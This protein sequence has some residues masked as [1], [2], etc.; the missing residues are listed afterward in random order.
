LRLNLATTIY[1]ASG[2]FQ[3]EVFNRA[4]S[5]LPQTVE[6][7][8]ASA[9]LGT[10]QLRVVAT[11]SSLGEILADVQVQP[12]AFTPQGDG[13]NDRAEISYSLFRILAGTAVSV[14][15]YTLSGRRIWRQIRTGQRAGRNRTFWDG[16]DDRGLMAPPGVYLAR[17]AVQTDQG[18]FA[19]VRNLALVY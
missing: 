15:I 19:Q 2:H 14:E 11:G 12:A 1:G 17:I 13:I 4:A 10:D 9:E 16:R 5:D 8:D 18:T 6:G 7:G 3:A